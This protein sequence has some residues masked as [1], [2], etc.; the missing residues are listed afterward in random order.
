MHTQPHKRAHTHLYARARAYIHTHTHLVAD[1]REILARGLSFA[2]AALRDSP[3][4]ANQ[5][6]QA[7]L[8]RTAASGGVEESDVM[9]K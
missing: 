7:H 9:K 2:E 4:T 5:I 6:R 8:S 3:E 1:S